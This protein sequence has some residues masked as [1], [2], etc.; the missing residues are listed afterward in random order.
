MSIKQSAT[1]LKLPF[2]RN[3]Y[4]E[5]IREAHLNDMS[6]KDFLDHLL[7]KEVELRMEN[8]ISNRIREAK[9]PFKIVMD[10]YERN[11]LSIEVRHKIKELET[12]E[13]IKNNENIILIGNPGTGKTA[14]S[15]ALGISA[16]HNNMNV[17]F[18]NIPNLLIELKEA[19][20]LNQVNRYKK[21]FEKY[22]LV[23]LDELGYCTFDQE[24]GEILFN[25][26]SSR[27]E[28]GS[29]IITSN[30]S[31]ER[32]EEVFKDKVL[33]GA[34]IDRLAYKS[35]MIDMTG[36]SYRL[37]STKKWIEENKN[38]NKKD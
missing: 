9:F 7:K 27:N 35:H 36:E 4:E 20:S 21:R 18:I 37:L 6:N 13:F 8:S 10:D 22:D 11:H 23:I 3:N 12:L 30:L 16:C 26:L 28:K 15:V 2:I 32:W 24:R 31:F 29:M 14:L 38:K 1:I 19:M 34:I 33:T 5:V 17:L 25:L